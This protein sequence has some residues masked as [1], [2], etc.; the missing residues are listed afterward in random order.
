MQL[1]INNI[2]Q[3]VRRNIDHLVIGH[4][5]GEQVGA[6][7]EFTIR[8]GCQLLFEIGLIILEGSDGGIVGC[9][10]FALELLILHDG[11]GRREASL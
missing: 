6:E 10:E 4:A 11:K 8:P 9:R 1:R 5:L 2:E 7:R 3:S